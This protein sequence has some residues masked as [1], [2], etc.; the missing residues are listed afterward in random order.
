MFEFKILVK[1]PVMPTARVKPKRAAFR[2]VALK[3]C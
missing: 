2:K 1:P 3:A